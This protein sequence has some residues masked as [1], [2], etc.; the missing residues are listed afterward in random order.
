MDLGLEAEV[1]V[2]I[3]YLIFSCAILR[4]AF[5]VLLFVAVFTLAIIEV[6]V[7]VA[8]RLTFGVCRA[9]VVAGNT[10]L[11]ILVVLVLT[12]AVAVAT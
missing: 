8:I 11:A 5:S 3:V 6:V 1:K 4:L 2:Y 7:A 9:F 12:H 10:L